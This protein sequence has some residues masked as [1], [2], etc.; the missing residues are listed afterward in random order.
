[1]ETRTVVAKEQAQKLAEVITSLPVPFTLSWREGDVRSLSQNALVHRWYSDIA[2]HYGDRD[3][4][5]VKGQC[6][7]DYG[8]DIR[9]QDP[10]FAYVYSKSVGKLP[11]EKQV[12]FWAKQSR[13]DESAVFYMTSVMTH[14]ELSTY[15]DAMGRHYRSRG[16]KLT[17]PK[18]I[19]A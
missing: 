12:D 17:D 14:I 2:R 5:E 16:V 15:M 6:H 9:M 3:M 10:L 7:V 11:Y 13:K 18:V 1:M 4:Y 19:Y 8:V